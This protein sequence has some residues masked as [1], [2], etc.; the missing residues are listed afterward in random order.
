MALGKVGFFGRLTLILSGLL[1]V[2]ASRPL[3]ELPVNNPII[4]QGKDPTY[5]VKYSSKDLQCMALNIY[6][7]ARSEPILSQYAVAYTVLNRVHS[8]RYSNNICTVIYDNRKGV[9]QFSW[10]CN[11]GKVKEI[12]AWEKS[13]FIAQ[14]ALDTYSRMNDPTYGALWYHAM[15]VYPKWAREFSIGIK[16]GDHVFYPEFGEKR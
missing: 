15:Y 16:Y 10:T 13:K 2:T 3:T 7:E 9:C 5:G 6:H 14:I 8:R 1:I 11:A 12:A 4:V